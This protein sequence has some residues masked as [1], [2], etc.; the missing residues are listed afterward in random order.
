M[1]LHQTV[2]AETLAWY[3]KHAQRQ[4]P[5]DDFETALNKWIKEEKEPGLFFLNEAGE[6]CIWGAGKFFFSFEFPDRRQISGTLSA[7]TAL[8]ILCT[9]TIGAQDQVTT[10]TRL[11]TGCSLFPNTRR[12]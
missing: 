6:R 5:D 7:L 3:Y 12:L 11:E 9:S 8:K 2:D 1:A 4:Y 10:N